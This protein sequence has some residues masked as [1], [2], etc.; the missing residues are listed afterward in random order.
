MHPECDPDQTKE[1][2]ITAT[3]PLSINKSHLSRGFLGAPLLATLAF[4]HLSEPIWLLLLIVDLPDLAT[5]IAK[6][7]SF[8]SVFTSSTGSN[9]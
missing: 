3:R 4:G 6:S 7:A 9:N 2:N 5:P 1:L 8:E